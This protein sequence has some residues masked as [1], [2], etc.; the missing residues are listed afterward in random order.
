MLRH[1][2]R[3]N[4]WR[5]GCLNGPFHK[6]LVLLGL[7]ISPTLECTLLPD[8]WNAISDAFRKGLQD[9][10]SQYESSIK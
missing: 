4:Q 6:L 5:K 7:R 2:L 10:G 8:E 9:G 3:W 1:I